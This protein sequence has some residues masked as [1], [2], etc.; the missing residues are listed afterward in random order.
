MRRVTRVK[1]SNSKIKSEP[2]TSISNESKQAEAICTNFSNYIKRFTPLKAKMDKFFSAYNRG[3]SW[4]KYFDFSNS[5][6][7][8]IEI[9]SVK[10]DQ[11]SLKDPQFNQKWGKL[12]DLILHKDK[13]GFSKSMKMLK[14]KIVIK[15]EIDSLVEFE[16]SIP[17]KAS[18]KKFKSNRRSEN[19]VK[20][21]SYLPGSRT[22][23]ASSVKLATTQTS[24]A[25]K[26]NALKPSDQHFGILPLKMVE[27]SPCESQDRFT[28]RALESQFPGNLNMNTVEK[29]LIPKS[30]YFRGERKLHSSVHRRRSSP[31]KTALSKS[32]QPFLSRVEE[33]PRKTNQKLLRL[34]LS[35]KHPIFKVNSS[36]KAH[37]K[38]N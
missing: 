37:K 5:Q 12:M 11:I 3:I 14:T 24:D 22:S 9:T 34:L 29:N 6:A 21:K 30:K 8:P 4:D 28:S 32:R 2:R 33:A 16:N 27:K 35:K 23:R 15:R 36:T 25:K 31:P 26:R 10:K 38:F 18:Y 19:Q 13:D 17:M 20:A 1:L 7:A